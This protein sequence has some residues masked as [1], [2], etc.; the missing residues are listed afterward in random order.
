M[1]QELGEGAV[2]IPERLACL[3]DKE[4]VVI[5]MPAEDQALT[6]FLENR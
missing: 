4:K 6:D 2:E 5:A 1:E 3:A